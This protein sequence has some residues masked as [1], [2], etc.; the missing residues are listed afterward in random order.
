MPTSSCS[1]A[2]CRHAPPS[3]AT[4]C[5]RSARPVRPARRPRCGRSRP[6]GRSARAQSERRQRADPG[7]TSTSCAG[8]TGSADGWVTVT[9]V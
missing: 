2:A 6:A 9:T 5:G 4:R 7:S 8:S 1:R 3:P